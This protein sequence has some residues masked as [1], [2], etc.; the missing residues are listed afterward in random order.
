MSWFAHD[1]PLAEGGFEPSDP[2]GRFES[3]SPSEASC[4]EQYCRC[5]APMATRQAQALLDYDR[6][7]IGWRTFGVISDSY[8]LI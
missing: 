8:A 2:L 3:V 5:L 7:F 1:S 4:L 6:R